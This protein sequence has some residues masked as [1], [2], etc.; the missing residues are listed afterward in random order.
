MA[1]IKKQVRPEGVVIA[2]ISPNAEKLEFM[3]STYP[4]GFGYSEAGNVVLFV[5]DHADN[6]EEAVVIEHIV[7]PK[8]LERIIEIA[9]ET[10]DNLGRHTLGVKLR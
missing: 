3:S 5:H 1:K 10:L 8:T 4:I 6:S 7:T 2:P 9:Q